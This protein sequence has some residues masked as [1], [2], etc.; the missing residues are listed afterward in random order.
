MHLGSWRHNS[1][2]GKPLSYLELADT[3]PKY[4]NSLGFTQV[5]F[6]PL[7]EFPFGASWGYQVS[8]YYAPTH[9]FGSP[10]DFSILVESL[11]QSG[12]GDHGLG[13]CTLSS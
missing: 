7:S 3:L 8:G 4:I 12:I 10:E 9:R 1:S 11:Q 6:M 13:A 5:E 2:T